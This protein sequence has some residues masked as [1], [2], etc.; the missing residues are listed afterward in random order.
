M[1]VEALFWFFPLVW[2]LGARLNAERERA[3]DESVLADGNDPQIYAEGILK[4]CRAYL[5][6]PLACVAGVSGA[7]LKKRIEAIMENRLVLRLNAARK[8]VLSASAAVALALPVALG[9]LAAP[10]VQMQAKA[11]QIPLPIKNAQR[12]TASCRPRPKPPSPLC[13]QARL[14]KIQLGGR[15]FKQMKQRRRTSMRTPF[16]EASASDSA[17]RPSN[18]RSILEELIAST[19]CLK[20]AGKR[21]LR[22]S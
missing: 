7:G 9:L 1:L 5:Q 8:F 10:V 17:A 16:S 13:R 15:R 4:V 11:A 14:R 12:S 21:P 6:S 3:C 2:W 19:L 20:S 22:F 18:N